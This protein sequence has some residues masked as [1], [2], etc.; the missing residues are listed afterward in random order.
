MHSEYLLVRRTEKRRLRNTLETEPRLKSLLHEDK[1]C[2]T[3]SV[4]SEESFPQE[5]PLG[6]QSITEGTM[7]TDITVPFTPL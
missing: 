5:T 2:C 4:Y 3:P 7:A 1:R 6:C